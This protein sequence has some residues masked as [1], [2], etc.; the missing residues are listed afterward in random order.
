MLYENRT[1]SLYVSQFHHYEINLSSLRNQ[2]WRECSG[3]TVPPWSLMNVPCSRPRMQVLWE[4]V[5]TLLAEVSVEITFNTKL[6][7]IIIHEYEMGDL[8]QHKDNIKER[9]LSNKKISSFSTFS[10][11]LPTEWE[12][13]DSELALFLE[14]PPRNTWMDPQHLCDYFLPRRLVSVQPTIAR[15]ATEEVLEN[16]T[17]QTCI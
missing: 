8:W 12:V 6:E 3:V 2:I 14:R 4:A 16:E 15:W 9:E 5:T 7:W 11:A 10:S 1:E 13:V 17:Q